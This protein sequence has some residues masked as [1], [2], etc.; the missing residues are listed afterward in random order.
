[1]LDR[2]V[3]K[4]MLNSTRTDKSPT[5]RRGVAGGWRDE[6]KAAHCVAFA[7][8]DVRWATEYGLEQP[9][10]VKLGFEDDMMW[11]KEFVEDKADTEGETDE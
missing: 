2:T 6:F 7:D 4:M 10:L 11:W 5:F 3:D 9:W 8:E 1:V